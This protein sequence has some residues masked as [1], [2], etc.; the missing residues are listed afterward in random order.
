MNNNNST[1]NN[2]SRTNELLENY[3]SGYFIDTSDDSI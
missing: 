1:I 3:L 2:K